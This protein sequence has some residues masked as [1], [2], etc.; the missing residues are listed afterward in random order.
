MLIETKLRSHIQSVQISDTLGSF[1]KIYQ[2]H[3]SSSKAWNT[4][5]YLRS[6][7]FSYEFPLLTFHEFLQLLY[8]LLELALQFFQ[9]LGLLSFDHCSFVFRGGQIRFDTFQL[10]SVLR[11]NTV[12]SRQSIGSYFSD[13]PER[14]SRKT[15][16][17]LIEDLLCDYRTRGGERVVPKLADSVSVP[18]A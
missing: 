11:A 14:S 17:R 7:D 3:V 6:F 1:T 4:I 2:E 16:S 10:L 9:T 13:R 8:L 18:V 12:N 5:T 15:L